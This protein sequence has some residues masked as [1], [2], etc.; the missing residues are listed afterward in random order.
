MSNFNGDLLDEGLQNVMCKDRCQVTGNFKKLDPDQQ[1]K[2]LE[3]ADKMFAD[4]FPDEKKATSS[5]KKTVPKAEQ[6]AMDAKWEPVKVNRTDM[7]KLKACAKDALLYGGLSS[8]FFYFQMAEQMTI[9]A[10]MICIVTCVLVGGV[11][12]GKHSVEV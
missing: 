2:I 7:D 11:K 6:K 3:M 4:E 9:T 5:K 12:I 8:V 1:K 10:S